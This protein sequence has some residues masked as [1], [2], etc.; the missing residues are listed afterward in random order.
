MEQYNDMIGRENLTREYKEFRFYISRSR[1]SNKVACEYCETGIWGDDFNAMVETNMLDYIKNYI[2]KYY[3][4]FMNSNITGSLYI[5][6][7]D[8]GFIKGIPYKGDFPIDMFNHKIIKSLQKY[9]KGYD[10][11][12]NRTIRIEWKE[13]HV[14]TNNILMDTFIPQ[15]TSYLNEKEKFDAKYNKW[16][17]SYE[18]W[19]IRFAFAS[20]KLVDLANTP[21]SRQLII[22]YIKEHDS[23]NPVIKQFESKDFI[24][25][26]KDHASLVPLKEDPNSPQYW[27]VRWKDELI[28]VIRKEKPTFH[29]DFLLMNAPLNIISNVGEMIPYWVSRNSNMKLYMLHITIMPSNMKKYRTYSY[30]EKSKK[31][32]ITNYRDL[33]NDGSPTSISY[34]SSD[35][36]D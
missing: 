8:Y 6:V 21:E 1:M 25:E 3:S 16:V 29:E 11:T 30:F 24:M 4:A 17:D 14:K 2:P 33:M 5:G 7:D 19:K 18:D 34:K 32:W 22:N 13:V 35:S 20:R 31:G 26:Y 15:Y 12:C 9:V 36:E 23:T 10:E 28:E 27:V